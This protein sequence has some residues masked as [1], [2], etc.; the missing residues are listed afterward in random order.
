ME[1][2]FDIILKENQKKE[3]VNAGYKGLAVDATDILFYLWPQIEYLHSHNK[4]YTKA[5]WEKI[6]ALYD[7]SK[8]LWDGL[9]G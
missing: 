9:D 6:D 3:L 1:N 2:T 7:I 5:Q 8:A 4:N